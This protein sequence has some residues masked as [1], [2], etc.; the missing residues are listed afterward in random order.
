[1]LKWGGKTE[2]ANDDHEKKTK[3]PLSLIGIQ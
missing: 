2:H 1:M 3:P